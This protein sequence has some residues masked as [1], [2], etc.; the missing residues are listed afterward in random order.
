MA[1]KPKGEPK[2]VQVIEC[3]LGYTGTNSRGEEYHIYNVKACTPNGEP[4]QQD[5]NSFE[6]LPLG[7]HTLMVTKYVRTKDGADKVSYTLAK[8][9]PPAGRRLDDLEKRVDT[10]EEFLRGK[11]AVQSQETP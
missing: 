8:I 4:I 9:K 1:D 10:L 11:F 3:T 6:D 7:E 2:K 5:L